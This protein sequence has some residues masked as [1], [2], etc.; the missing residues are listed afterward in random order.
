MA[1]KKQTI[2]VKTRKKAKLLTLEQIE[3]QTTELALTMTLE[4]FFINSK[5][6]EALKAVA[7]QKIARLKLEELKKQNEPQDKPIDPIKV[8]FVSS[9]TAESLNR[10]DKLTNEVEESIGVKKNYA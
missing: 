4:N 1:K 3:E 7:D 5:K 10:V 2:A 6:I 9:T 8:E